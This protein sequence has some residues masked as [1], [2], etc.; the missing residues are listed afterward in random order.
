MSEVSDEVVNK[1]EDEYEYDDDFE[2]MSKSQLHVSMGKVNVK[3]NL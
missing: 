1:D 2:S 3:K